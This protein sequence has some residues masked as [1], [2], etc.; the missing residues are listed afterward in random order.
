[1]ARASKATMSVDM[2]SP[3]TEQLLSARR[4]WFRR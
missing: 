1:M 2:P 3:S 4:M